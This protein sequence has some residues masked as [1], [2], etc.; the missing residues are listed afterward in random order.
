MRRT[1]LSIVIGFALTVLQAQAS[2]ISI[3]SPRV[4]LSGIE[5]T[6]SVY[7]LEG[8]SVTVRHNG[9]DIGSSAQSDSL[10]NV[11]LLQ[12]STGS[13]VITVIGDGEILAESSINV[14]PAWMSVVPPLFAILLSFVLRSVIPSLFAGLIV[15]AWAIN[16]MTFHGAVV[17]VFD[18]MTIY[19]LD[20][21]IDP[22]HGSIILFSLLIGGMV[23]IV[24]RNGG[25]MGIVNRV[26]PIARTPRRGQAVIAVLGL[27]IFFDDY[28]NTMIVG[29]ATRP[30]SDHLRISR[31]KLAYLVD[32]TAA[33]VATIAVIT[34][35]I[36]FQ[37]GL[38]EEAISGI[39][40]ISQ[41]AYSLFLQSIP[42]S[43]YPFLAIFFV[44]V[45]VLTGKDFGPMYHAEM[46]A[47]TTGAVSAK[48]VKKSDDNQMDDFECKDDIPCRAINALIPIAC[49]VGGVIGGMYIS[50]EG[51]SLQEIIGS[52][53][54][55][56]VLIWA[57]LLACIA[58]FALTLGQ[59]L[60]SLNEAIDAWVIGARF[61][62]TGI[63]LLVMAWAIADV[64]G[65]LQTAPYLISVL[66]NSLS[67]YM[68]PS[69]IFLLAAGAGFASGSSWG[70]MAILMPLVI[71]LCWAVLEVNNIADAQHMHILYSSIA[72]VLTGAVWA[73]H[74]SPISDTTVLSS[75]ATG[76]DHMDH[77]STQL[78][79]ALLGG[80]VAML[81][82]TL[83]AGYG[84]PWWLLLPSAAVVM[85]AFHR[86]LAKP[87]D[88]LP[89]DLSEDPATV[90]S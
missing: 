16:G 41:T 52:A 78:P 55:Y 29:N 68:L 50:G 24:S 89:G 79:Y 58:A 86:F 4:M 23:G 45:V 80:T 15:G 67:P 12:P 64:A 71:P 25:M 18:T 37:V 35:W 46:R 1:F 66:G 7:G 21:M 61:M 14:I 88:L 75:L 38:I 51:D 53:N 56:V 30:V 48:I 17:G 84:L 43:F 69:I 9:Q 74:C 83:P 36:G 60:L 62:L 13:A 39:D 42:Y 31:E 32:S 77:V 33:P 65:I 57:S 54:A 28:A 85:F 87:T 90:Q 44:F 73:D 70:V 27:G 49:L 20:A 81:V 6:F 63:V 34:T 72:C 47:R 82:C 2:E 76:C 11:V 22:D 5:A 19:V 10:E 8:Q 59:G 3:D 26:I 40:G